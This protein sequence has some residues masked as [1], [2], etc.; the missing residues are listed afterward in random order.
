M[1][2]FEVVYFLQDR[3]FVF[4]YNEQIARQV[5]GDFSSNPLEQLEN[6]VSYI[7]RIVRARDWG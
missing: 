7:K 3:K 1:E 5:E 2:D 6:E 4:H